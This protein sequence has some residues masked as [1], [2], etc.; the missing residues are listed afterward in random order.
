MAG[1]PLRLAREAC[2]AVVRNLRPDDMFTLVVFDNSAQ[3]VIPLQKPLDRHEMIAA[4]EQ[5]GDRG[6]TN[7]MAGWLLGR[8]ELLKV[9]A[10]CDKKIL[11]LTDGHLNQGI[12]EP[13]RVEA[14]T[15]S[16]SLSA[17]ACGP[18]PCAAY[19]KNPVELLISRWYW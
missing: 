11:V 8:D 2:A 16:C 14:L 6:S 5:I 15:R 9:G 13:D 3:V 4:I 19:P 18:T 17:S 10:E 12:T 1:E 7:L